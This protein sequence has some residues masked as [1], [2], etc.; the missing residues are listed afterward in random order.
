MTSDEMTAAVNLVTANPTVEDLIAGSGGCRKVRVPGKREEASRAVIAWSLSSAAK[1]Y[2]CSFSLC[3]RRDREL[4]S[5]RR[6][7]TQ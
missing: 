5:R 2:R 7:A 4:T 1:M 3:C 6:N